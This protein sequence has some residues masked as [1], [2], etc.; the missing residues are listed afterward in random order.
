M[1]ELADVIDMLKAGVAAA[2]NAVN[3][4]AHV[5]SVAEDL[6]AKVQEG[7]IGGVVRVGEDVVRAVDD[8]AAKVHALFDQAQGNAP[9]PAPVSHVKVL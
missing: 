3:D 1:S 2:Q 7:N 8:L 9:A 5:L 4:L 6:L